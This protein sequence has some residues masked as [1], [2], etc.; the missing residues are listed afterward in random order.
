MMPSV[1]STRLVE[2]R[3]PTNSGTSI[4][5]GISAEKTLIIDE[6]CGF[7]LGVDAKLVEVALFRENKTFID[8]VIPVD[9]PPPIGDESCGQMLGEGSIDKVVVETVAGVFSLQSVMWPSK[10]Y[11]LGHLRPHL[12]FWSE[13]H[14]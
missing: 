10:K 9:E 1:D 5:P 14:S 3:F 12:R 8:A 4:D 13:V 2:E 7:V 11:P 6:R